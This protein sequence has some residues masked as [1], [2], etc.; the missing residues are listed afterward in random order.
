M[1][2]DFICWHS[3]RLVSMPVI[4]TQHCVHQI[5]LKRHHA[6]SWDET[7]RC[8]ANSN[9]SQC[10][11][12]LA[13]LLQSMSLGTCVYTYIYPCLQLV[14]AFILYM[15]AYPCSRHVALQSVLHT[16]L[17][18]ILCIRRSALGCCTLAQL[19]VSLTI[20]CLV[21]KAMEISTLTD[22]KVF[23]HAACCM[24]F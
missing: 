14:H 22:G 24:I 23:L 15:L 10:L 17:P 7:L 21:F 16:Q 12:P 18:V 1:L 19:H 6:A 8:R 4:P 3:P 20:F 13:V 9:L 5:L 2:H 11:C